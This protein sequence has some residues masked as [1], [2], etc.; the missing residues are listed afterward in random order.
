MEEGLVV[1]QLAS[2]GFGCWG[3]SGGLEGSLYHTCRQKF[4]LPFGNTRTAAAAA[5]SVM[6]VSVG[7]GKKKV[8][9]LQPPIFMAISHKL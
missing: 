2:E 4:V 8:A 1:L 7:D 6:Y 5:A 9:I 3:F